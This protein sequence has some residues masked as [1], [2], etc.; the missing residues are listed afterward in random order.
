MNKTFTIYKVMS[1]QPEDKQLSKEVLKNPPAWF[2]ENIE[3]PVDDAFVEV[4]GAQIH[5][6]RWRPKTPEPQT[7]LLFVHGN[8]A[9]AHWWDFIAPAFRERFDVAA[10]DMSGAGDSDHRQTYTPSTFT[11]EIMTIAEHAGFNR[12]LIV[13]HSFGG[14]M[15]RIAG[16]LRGSDLG[17]IILVDSA[18]SGTKGKRHVPGAPRGKVRYFES[19]DEAVRRFRLRPAQPCQNQYI[20]DYIAAHSVKQTNQGYTFKL[21][22][23]LFS[24]MTEDDQYDFPD[25]MTMLREIPCKVGLIYGDNS[26]FFPPEQVSRI[27]PLFEPGLMDVIHGAHHHVFLDQPLTFIDSLNRMLDQIMRA[28]PSD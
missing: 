6:Q 17:G 3:T 22:Q 15:A 1:I 27:S 21:D 4:D 19:M 23:S 14:S 12:P 25:G 5:Y 10:L 9:H 2:Q 8:G 20:L 7:G 11:R 26:R 24:R 13:G 28:P 16:W 18:I